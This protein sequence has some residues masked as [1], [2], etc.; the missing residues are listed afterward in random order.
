[1]CVRTG[2]SESVLTKGQISVNVKMAIIKGRLLYKH[3]KRSVCICIIYSYME[4]DG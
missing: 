1:M 2:L 3:E 4:T